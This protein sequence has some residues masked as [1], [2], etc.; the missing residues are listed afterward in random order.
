MILIALTSC[1]FSVKRFCIYI[2]VVGTKMSHHHLDILSEKD[3]FIKTK[4]RV[5]GVIDSGLMQS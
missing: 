5:V 2:I 3:S 4:T 1:S